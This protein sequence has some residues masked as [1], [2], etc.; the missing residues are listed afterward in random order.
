[1]IDVHSHFL[2]QIDDGPRQV[3]ESIAMLGDSYQQGVTVCAGTSHLVLHRE[4]S[5]ELFLEQR[6]NAIVSLEKALE[7]IGTVV[8][9]LLYGAEV[10]LDND[11]SKFDGLKRLCISG[12]NLLLVELP[13]KKYNQNYAE[14]LYLLNLK[15]IVP[16]IAH[17]ERYSYIKVLLEELES[18]N[19][20][21]QIN[22][23][24]IL[25]NKWFKFLLN[26][27]Y[28]EK[29]V[30]VSSDMH[31]MGTRK[32]CI[33]KAYDKVCKHYSK[34]IADDIF[35]KNAAKLIGLDLK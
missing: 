20:V 26:L 33:K 2:P 31:N 24:T 35:E 22:A 1:M 15:G 21:Y 30:L 17:I 10:L 6:D 11:I 12:T 32:S 28:H 34:H 14:W 27:Y 4:G 25:K 23:K 9:K 18:V 7:D 29:S 8:P 19:V 16:I 3:N 13:T 5:I